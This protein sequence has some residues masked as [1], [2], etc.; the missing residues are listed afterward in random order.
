GNYCEPVFVKEVWATTVVTNQTLPAIAKVETVDKQHQPQIEKANV[1]VEAQVQGKSAAQIQKEKAE[2]KAC[3]PL[4]PG[5]VYSTS[6]CAT[7][8]NPS[9]FA[10]AGME[11]PT[12][13]A[14]GPAPAAPAAAPAKS[15]AYQYQGNGVRGTFVTSVSERSS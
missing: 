9:R 10:K 3:A 8:E 7:R 12:A 5:E 6:F 14:A 1:L 13:I 15:A 11:A 4:A 2:L